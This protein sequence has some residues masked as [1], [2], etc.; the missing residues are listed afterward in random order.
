M[1]NSSARVR[2]KTSGPPGAGCVS[3]EGGSSPGG[4]HGPMGAIRSGFQAGAASFAH[5]NKIEAD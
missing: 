2:A 1:T 4:Y 3:A 5:R